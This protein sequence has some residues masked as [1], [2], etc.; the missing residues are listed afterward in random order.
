M[1]LKSLQSGRF[2][3]HGVGVKRILSLQS[4]RRPERPADFA[5][6][7]T[8]SRGLVRA[9]V[10]EYTR[11]GDVVFDPFTGFG[12]TLEVAEQLGRRPLGFEILPDRVDHVRTRLTD[13]E[14]IR[15]EDARTVDWG[16]LP[17]IDFCMG[18]PPY[19]TK[20]DHAQNPLSGYRTQD[21]DYA[22][23]L[24][25]LTDIYRRIAEHCSPDARIVINVANLTLERTCLAWD[26]GTAVGRVLDFERE[27]IIDWSEPQ[28]WFTQD[29][30]LV[31]RPR[32]G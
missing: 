6:D 3:G 21:G 10:E 9:F 30:C 4:E 29:Y 16:T 7:L 18:S 26:V 2:P 28:D 24:A 14:A 11:P 19:M 1:R 8:Y 12:T 20:V 32:S 13:P 23:Y 5:D 27:V 31:F 22:A 17:M 15:V 25:D